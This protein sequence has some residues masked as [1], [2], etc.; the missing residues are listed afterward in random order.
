MIMVYFAITIPLTVLVLGVVYAFW[1]LL[2]EKLEIEV[3]KT[4]ER[5]E[6]GYN[7]SRSAAPQLTL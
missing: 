4:K 5:R 1:R 3:Y 6:A 2:D 7:D